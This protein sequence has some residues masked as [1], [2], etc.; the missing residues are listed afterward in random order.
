MIN[1]MVLM[2]SNNIYTITLIIAIFN[3]VRLESWKR[4]MWLCSW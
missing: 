4:Q 3:T 1:T 2:I